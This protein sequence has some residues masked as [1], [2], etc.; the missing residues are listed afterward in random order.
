[1]A[2]RKPPAEW[3]VQQHTAVRDLIRDARRQTGDSQKTVSQAAGVGLR[4]VAALE[5]EGRTHRPRA[6][7]L[8]RL[9]TALGINPS[10]LLNRAGYA[11]ISED[12]IRKTAS[13]V[14]R[15][16]ARLEVD[17]SEFFSSIKARI[18]PAKPVLFCVAY[19]APPGSA[20]RADV[21][22]ML[23][24][25]IDRGMWL[26][27]V[28]PYPIIDV[29]ASPKPNLTNFFKHVH[30]QVVATAFELSERTSPRKRKQIAVF[31]PRVKDSYGATL[32][33][34]PPISSSETR[35]ALIRWYG[36]TE[37]EQ[38]ELGAWV[39]YAH[40]QRDVWYTVFSRRDGLRVG[41]HDLN[42]L[43]AW[44]DYFRDIMTGFDPYRGKGW[45]D[46]IDVWA[47]VRI[48]GK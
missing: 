48:P 38:F 13:F 42:I 10:N 17:P 30:G 14:K 19:S 24:E 5:A 46:D 39:T 25:L 40:D 34:T 20:H 11:R 23:V 2:D 27:M 8:A 29:E 36:A 16:P 18:T 1:M 33:T 3:T 4:T 47:K 12:R 28:V 41:G 32:F 26:A 45:R 21:K 15:Y 22:S 35:S 43:P 31:V 44:K 6:E 7:I 37:Q 9:A